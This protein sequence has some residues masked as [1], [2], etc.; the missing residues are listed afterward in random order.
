M[1]LAVAALWI[2]L[3][4]VGLLAH[5]YVPDYPLARFTG[6]LAYCLICF[7]CEHVSGWGPH[8]PVLPFATLLS[9]WLIWRHHRILI[10]RW[11]SE[12]L[13]MAGFGYCLIWLYTFPNIDRFGEKMPNLMMI[14]AYMR[15]S[16]LPALDLWMSPYS[17]N[18]YYSFQHYC[19][20]LMGRIINLNPGVTY[21]IAYCALGGF[22]VMLSG[23]C[24]SRF[25]SWPLGRWLGVLSLLVGGSGTVAGAHLFL[26]KV[27]LVDCVRFLGGSMIH[28]PFTPLGLKVSQLMQTPGVITHDLPMEPLSYILVTGD[29]HP[30]LIGY[31]LLAFAASIIAAQASRADMH[32]SFVED[33]LLTATIPTTLMA[34]AWV[35]PLQSLLIAAWLGYR[36]LRRDWTWLKPAMI[37]AV[38]ASILCYPF[39]VEFTQQSIVNNAS[40]SFTPA[41]ERTPW[42]GWL[43]TFWPVLGIILLSLWDKERRQVTLFLVVFWTLALAGTEFCYNHDLYGGSW[44]RFNTTMKWWP[45]VYA[46]I[47]L[48]L[49]ASNLGS[50]STI[51]RYGTVL[52]IIPSLIS[53]IDLSVEFAGET[54]A[55]SGRL[56]G[57]GWIRD[58]VVRDVIAA[59]KAKP[60]GIA[61]ESG[62]KMENTD[63]PEVVLFAGKPCFLGWPWH[64]TTWRGPYLEIRERAEL[65]RAFYEG[66]SRDPLAWL[67]HNDIRYVLWLPQDNVEENA[68]FAPL[69]EKIRSRYFW[70]NMYGHDPHLQIG[71][72]E[73][74]ENPAGP[75]RQIPQPPPG[76]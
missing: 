36:L 70:H 46:G 68:R 47:L 51:C 14:T 42:I 45:W 28:G 31:A 39:L 37:G 8:P 54:K 49:G 38:I 35:F 57:S 44:S 20:A 76:N 74:I 66:K 10:S 73:R 25:C 62:P 52:L 56:E 58:P 17:L 72:W 26:A 3:L 67:L 64:E 55:F 43:L 18:F 21:H 65:V 60:D 63:S 59:L 27:K 30:P 41:A 24:I 23:N 13:F 4:G 71:F 33:L 1:C 69:D 40:L 75:V 50:R 48:T 61:L 6:V 12:A 2:N 34:N 32:A 53:I 29:Y 15:G 19:A 22:I 16:R 9:L 7:F 5:K 11:A